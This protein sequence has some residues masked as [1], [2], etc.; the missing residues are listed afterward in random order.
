[1][2]VA[3]RVSKRVVVQKRVV[4]TQRV[5][6]LKKQDAF[7]EATLWPERVRLLELRYMAPLICSQGFL[8]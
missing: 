6:L 7:N 3:K 4:V 5:V 8:I 1:M 2:V